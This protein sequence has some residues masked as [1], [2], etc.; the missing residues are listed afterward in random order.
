M[1]RQPTLRDDL[2]ALPLDGIDDLWLL[3][4]GLPAGY[5][6]P[7]LVLRWQGR[8]SA[9]YAIGHEERP[10]ALPLDPAKGGAFGNHL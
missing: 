8:D 4:T 2:A 10:G 7:R 3:D 6:N 5:R 9:L 1:R